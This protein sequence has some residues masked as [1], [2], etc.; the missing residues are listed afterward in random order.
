MKTAIGNCLVHRGRPDNDNPY[1][2]QSLSGAARQNAL[3]AF[4]DGEDTQEFTYWHA[5]CGG[6]AF[7]IIDPLKVDWLGMR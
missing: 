5:P 3:Q 4:R 7:E 2:G 1:K 6:G